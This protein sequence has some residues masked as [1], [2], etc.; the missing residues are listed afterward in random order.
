VPTT[1]NSIN[2]VEVR[3]GEV[4]AGVVAAKVIVERLGSDI[5]LSETFTLQHS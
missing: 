5:P 1:E 2:F 3:F 4:C